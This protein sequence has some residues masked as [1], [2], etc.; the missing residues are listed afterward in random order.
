MPSACTHIGS[1][2]RNCTL[3]SSPLC[4]HDRQRLVAQYPHT[5]HR[6]GQAVD[7][8]AERPP[9]DVVVAS[10]E[11]QVVKAWGGQPLQVDCAVAQTDLVLIPGFLFT[12]KEALPTFPA[13]APWLREQ[14]AAR[15]WRRCARQPL[16]CIDRRRKKTG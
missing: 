8:F 2:P 3:L 16:S 12:L 1:S 10:L 7:R 11:G 15:Y 4:A 6:G 9:F 5:Y 13:Y 14:H